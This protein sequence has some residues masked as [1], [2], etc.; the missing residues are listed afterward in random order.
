M[1]VQ[2]E[3]GQDVILHNGKTEIILSFLCWIDSNSLYFVV[4]VLLH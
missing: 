2:R 1:A 3:T 4:Q